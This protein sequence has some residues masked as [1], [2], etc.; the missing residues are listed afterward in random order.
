MP[1]GSPSFPAT[2]S[3]DPPEKVANWRPLVNW[4]LAIPH[5]A[6]LYVLQIVSRVVGVISWFAI[7]FTGKLP[8]GLANVQVMYLRYTL[9][10]YSFA[11]FMREEYPPFGFDTT[12]S[13]PGDDPRVRVDVQPELTDRN[14]LTA[15]FRIILAIPQ[16]IV[17]LVLVFAA[18]VVTVIAFFAVLFTGQWPAG[19]RDFV[20]KTWRW[21]L[22]VEVYLA[23]LTD[24][25]P[26]FALD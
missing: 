18:F 14:R 8:Q 13:D 26:P 9:R 21:Q 6:V 7:L 11:G 2:F 19:M 23:L 17:L 10:T 12:A 15:F 4:L 5:F 3:F 1:E 20:V 25:Y 24:T 22:R 16:L